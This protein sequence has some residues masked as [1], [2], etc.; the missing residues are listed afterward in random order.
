MAVGE[1][2]DAHS[3][4]HPFEY[5]AVTSTFKALRP[6]GSGYAQARAINGHG[7]IALYAE[8]AGASFI[9]C[10]K[11]NGCPTTGGAAARGR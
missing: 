11:I 8:D 4:P 7:L 10:P 2:L 3:R 5:N 9:Y 6:P 1:W